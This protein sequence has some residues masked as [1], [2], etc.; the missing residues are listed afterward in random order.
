M[1][2]NFIN[3]HLFS[4]IIF[5]LKSFPE[6]VYVSLYLLFLVMFFTVFLPLKKKI[7]NPLFKKYAGFIAIR[8]KKYARFLEIN[9]NFI[10]IALI[11]LSFPFN[12][13]IILFLRPQD[14][15]V[16]FFIALNIKY[17]RYEYIKLI[18][19]LSLSLIGSCLIGYLFFDNFYYIKLA[20]MYKIITPILFICTLLNFFKVNKKFKIYYYITNLT[21]GFYLFY[22]LFFY[23]F[24]PYFFSISIP[25]Y[26]S[27][28]SIFNSV[29]QDYNI[30]KHVM[31]AIV[32]L[33]LSVNLIYQ[34]EYSNQSIPKKFYNTFIILIL[35]LIFT[36]LFESRGLYLYMLIIIYL[37]TNYLFKRVFSVNLQKRI[38]IF[39]IPLISIFLITFILE[40]LNSY[41]LY[42]IKYLYKIFLSEIT[43]VGVHASRLIGW[44]DLVPHNLIPLLL[45][46]G[47]TSYNQI[48]LDSG[49]LF[50]ILNI[51][52]LPFIFFAFYI[53][54]N[55][56]F[57]IEL[58]FSLKFIFYSTIIINLIISEYFTVSRY[59]FV[60]SILYFLFKNKT[61]TFIS[62]QKK[63]KD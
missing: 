15:F 41:Y 51:G 31:G 18:L 34:I 30:D 40:N 7:I 4:Q 57:K 42:E 5:K 58:P 6:D 12:Y 8:F 60:A 26:P 35:G 39:F 33:F 9:I 38:S 22:I 36:K 20:F 54:K 47:M 16:V 53:V 49:L 10:L 37:T 17:I 63:Y 28:I 24:D 25:A 29:S 56:N 27:S 13:K 46:R 3:S 61:E 55:F 1:F 59:V 19:F 21:F 62:K 52:I 43:E 32:G 44:Y 48:F 50:I 2:M 11:I 23:Y 45:G 14:I